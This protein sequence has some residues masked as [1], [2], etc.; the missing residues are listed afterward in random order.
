VA[1]KSALA[2][3]FRQDIFD[4]PQASVKKPPPHGVPDGG[5]PVRAIPL[6]GL[7]D[8][9]QSKPCSFRAGAQREAEGVKVG[10][11]DL[12]DDPARGGKRGLVLAGET[13]DEV[14]AK[15][16]VRQAVADLGDGGAIGRH[17]VRTPHRTEDVVA[18]SLQ[19]N[20]EVRA[21]PR[22][23]GED[24]E[25]AVRDTGDVEGRE[26]QADEMLDI[27]EPLMLEVAGGRA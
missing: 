25:E 11:A 22:V 26:A 23:L 9:C 16:G 12:L 8:R 20:V 27:L 14:R 1:L 10:E 19:G 15:R 13:H 18:A 2:L 17:R 5:K 6:N 3:C 24:V 21:Q 4:L 7:G